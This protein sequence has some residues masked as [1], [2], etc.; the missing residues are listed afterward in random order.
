MHVCVRVCVRACM[1]VCMC[2]ACMYLCMYV[3]MCVCVYV[4]VYIMLVLIL[5]NLA[6]L[7]A[8]AAVCFWR[9]RQNTG[10]NANP[11]REAAEREAIRTALNGGSSGCFNRNESEMA[12]DMILSSS[13]PAPEQPQVN[14]REVSYACELGKPKS[15]WAS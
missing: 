1:Y 14:L 15:A 9:H 5:Y 2:H 7:V 6:S 10:S 3:C 11:C 13:D 8:G 4:C 12:R